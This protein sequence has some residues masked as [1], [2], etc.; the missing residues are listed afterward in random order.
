[1]T[2]L[3]PAERG[4]RALRR[5]AERVT[6]ELQAQ[7]AAWRGSGWTRRRFIAGLGMVGAATL[8]SQLVTTRAAF[9]ATPQ[10]T[11]D[12]SGRTLVV[13]FMR[14]AADG[15][16]ILAPQSADLGLTYLRQ[17]RPK[18]IPVDP[19]PLGGGWGANSALR[20]LLDELWATGEI[21]FVPGVSSPGIT[22][23][24]FQA[25]QYIEKGGSEGGTSGWLDRIL[26]GLGPGTTWRAVSV[27]SP[28]PLSL[29]GPQRSMAIG[30][31]A[32]F[33]MPGWDDIQGPTATALQKLYRG[34]TNTLGQDVPLTIQALSTAAAARA[35]AAVGNGAQ[36]PDSPLSTSLRDLA[37]LLR[38]EVGLQV[39]TIDVGGWDTHTLEERELDPNLEM[40]SKSLAAFMQDLGPDRRKRVT[41]AVMTEFGRRVEMNASAGTDHGHGSVMWLLGGGL[42]QRGVRGRWS[43]LSASVLDQGDVPGVNNPFDVLG[44]LVQ[45]RLGAGSLSTVF[46]GHTLQPLGIATTT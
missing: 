27:G 22:R 13:I 19:I 30:E 33:T 21:A 10:G 3:S 16:R 39:A 38:A 7:D 11:V 2:D 32:D 26:E 5:H 35:D 12:T 9:G 37:T 14:G 4:E 40:F 1:M 42:A 31:L 15:L 44:E 41:V 17:V 8:A 25:Q 36:Y 34:V 46:P 24:H 28:T 45:K 29:L 6:C 18:L 43:P 23:S 20:P